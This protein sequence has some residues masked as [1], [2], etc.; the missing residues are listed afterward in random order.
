MVPVFGNPFPQ[1]PGKLLIAVIADA[2]LLVRGNIGGVDIA[3]GRGHRQAAGKR[4]AARSGMAG[5]AVA[6]RHQ[7]FRAV[8]IKIVCGFRLRGGGQQGQRQQGKQ[9]DPLRTHKI[10]SFCQAW[11]SGPGWAKYWWRIALAANSAVAQ[12]MPVGL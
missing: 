8:N 3:D 9:S 12:T 10:P 6:G 4:L 7:R 5:D 2:G 1:G 11:T